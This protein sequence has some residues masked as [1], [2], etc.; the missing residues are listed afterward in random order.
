[1]SFPVLKSI[2]LCVNNL[3]FNVS[4]K[5]LLAQFYMQNMTS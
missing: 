4:K 2:R 1:M 3:N 5:L